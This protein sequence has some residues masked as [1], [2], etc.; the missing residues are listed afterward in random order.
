LDEYSYHNEETINLVVRPFLTVQHGYRPNQLII[1]STPS[2]KTNH[3]FG[4]YTRH[5]EKSIKS[6]DL[7][8]CTSFN[9]LDVILANHSLYRVDINFI[10]ENFKDQTL[11]DF[12]MEY[13]GYFPVEGSGFFPGWLIT[14]CEPRINTVEMEFFGDDDCEYV[15]GVDPARSDAGDNFALTIMKLLPDQKRHIVRVV[16]TRGKS[17]PEL[18]DLIRE[19]IFIRRFNVIKICMDY[20]GGG[21]AIQD[22]LIQSWS[23]NS[24][25]YPSIGTKENVLDIDNFDS[26]RIL[27]ILEMV[28]FNV[29]IIDYMYTTLKADMEHKKILFPITIRRDPD[30]EIETAG[31]EFAMLKSEMQHLTPKA[32]TRG[33]T[34]LENPKIGKDRITSCILANYAANIVYKK[35]FIDEKR[36]NII[37]PMGYWI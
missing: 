8:S 6:P 2:Y 3:F 37:V 27:P 25:S 29:P 31:K 24:I 18:A 14:Q 28:H 10:Y 22:L 26:K 7:Y 33:L 30:F 34:F 32:T 11:D 17:F 19:Q 4:Q 12:L 21:N 35:E 20:G 5:K 13:G 9:F 15:M 23:Y 36:Q 1:C 16:S